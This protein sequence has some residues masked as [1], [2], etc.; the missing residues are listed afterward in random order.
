MFYG[1]DMDFIFL[2]DK[3]YYSTDKFLNIK[4]YN[5]K[6]LNQIEFD[7]NIINLHHLK[8]QI[9]VQLSNSIHCYS[10][11]GSLIYQI[12]IPGQILSLT[13]FPLGILVSTNHS[14]DAPEFDFVYDG[15]TNSTLVWIDST[16]SIRAWRNYHDK[17]ISMASLASSNEW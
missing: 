13:S 9:Y 3:F 1:P 4:A 16:G 7:T 14:T 17:I 8:S 12:S 11:S 10:T 5:G 6:F 2:E 15:D